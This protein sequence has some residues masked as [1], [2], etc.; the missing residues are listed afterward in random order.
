MRLIG[1]LIEH[2][3]RWMAR[4]KVALDYAEGRDWHR[5]TPVRVGAN[6]TQARARTRPGTLR[7]DYVF[8]E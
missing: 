1:S 8:A 3:H 6:A 2:L 5:P 7:H 4:Y